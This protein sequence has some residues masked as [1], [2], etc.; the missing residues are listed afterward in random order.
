[1][2]LVCIGNAGSNSAGSRANMNRMPNLGPNGTGFFSRNKDYMV[3]LDELSAGYIRSRA[4]AAH[5]FFNYSRY[6]LKR[7]F[8]TSLPVEEF[9]QTKNVEK[10]LQEIKRKNPYSTKRTSWK[11]SISPKNIILRFWILPQPI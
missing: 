8:D 3:L 1:L 11:T 2:T 6:A 10:L 7:Y 9:N 4:D 5:T